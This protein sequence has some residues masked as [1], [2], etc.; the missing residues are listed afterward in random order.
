MRLSDNFVYCFIHKTRS[1]NDTMPVIV[2]Y[3]HTPGCSNKV[4]NHLVAQYDPPYSHCDLQFEDGM[5]SSVYQHCGAIWRACDFNRAQRVE[6]EVS[7]DGYQRAYEMCSRRAEL[8]YTFDF[9]GAYG[10]ALQKSTATHSSDRTFCSKNCVEAL[11][12][13]GVGKL[14]GMDASATTPSALFRA[15]EN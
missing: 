12:I 3:F 10:F 4:L 5:M 9:E 6:I 15:L 1:S 2:V 8:G 13:A 14:V 11:Q 7:D